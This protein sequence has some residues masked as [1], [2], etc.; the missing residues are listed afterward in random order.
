MWHEQANAT[1]KCD[2]SERR[3]ASESNSKYEEPENEI[4]ALSSLEKTAV[5]G[6]QTEHNEGESGKL[7]HSK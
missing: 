5:A 7:T 4:R 2:H 6:G 3:L 1:A